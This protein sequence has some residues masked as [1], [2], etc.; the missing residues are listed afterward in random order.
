M[1]KDKQYISNDYPS[2][3]EYNPQN[4]NPQVNITLKDLK[5]FIQNN[6]DLPDDTIV[7]CQRVNDVY[8]EHMDWHTVKIHEEDVSFTLENH[9]K[10]RLEQI[11]EHYKNI[12]L[13]PTLVKFEENENGLFVKQYVDCLASFS[14]SVRVWEKTNQNMILITPFY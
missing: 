12:C 1:S 13:D 6:P 11:K 8:F 5:E 4:V 2:A 10:E 3:K 9:T 14:I 7:L